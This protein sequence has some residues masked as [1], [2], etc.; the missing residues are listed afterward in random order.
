MAKK[1]KPNPRL[2][3]SERSDLYFQRKYRRGTIPIFL[4]GAA[5][6]AAYAYYSMKQGHGGTYYAVAAVLAGLAV[7]QFI[8]TRAAQVSGT[9]VDARAQ[10]VKKEIDL[11]KL[12]LN[13]TDM[14]IDDFE[15]TEKVYLAGYTTLPIEK[16]PPL[17]RADPLDGRG[18]S[19]YLQLSCF[20]L[21]ADRMEAFSLVRSLLKPEDA[22]ENMTWR[23]EHIAQIRIEEV[24]A[25]CAKESG[26]EE[27]VTKKFPVI[28]IRSDNKKVRRTYAF[29]EADRPAAEEFVARIQE[30]SSM[31]QKGK[32]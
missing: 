32:E 18:R 27:T 16:T 25:A 6:A 1:K 22:Q 24:S 31:T 3:Q 21:G 4:I 7:W 30:K 26:G 17:L 10:Q 9:E 12:A 5:L 8:Y 15:T 13:A 14:D 28:S 19:S 29:E 20:V 23:Y 11:D 2:Y